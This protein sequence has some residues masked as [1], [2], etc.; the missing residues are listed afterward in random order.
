[1][2]PILLMIPV[3]VA[4]TCAFMTPIA[5]PCNAFVFGEMKGVRLSKMVLCGFF[6]NILCV[7]CV[8][9]WLPICIPLIYSSEAVFTF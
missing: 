1:I 3:S 4:S 5:T 8:S 7:L 9:F 6:L 2:N